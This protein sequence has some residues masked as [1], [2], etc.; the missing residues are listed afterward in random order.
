MIGEHS[1]G[2][3]LPLFLEQ[4]RVCVAWLTH[5]AD[6]LLQVLL[7]PGGCVRA[8]CMLRGLASCVRA[9]T[10][11]YAAFCSPVQASVA[12]RQTL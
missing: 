6:T 8:G 11:E 1:Q 12:R 2:G 9:V 3:S 4:T 10:C 5:T 7:L